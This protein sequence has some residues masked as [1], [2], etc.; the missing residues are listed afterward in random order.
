MP[1]SSRN[2]V[3]K[4]LGPDGVAPAP[5]PS[6]AAAALAVAAPSGF[7]MALA[8][9]TET[10]W[11]AWAAPTIVAAVWTSSPANARK[12]LRRPR[13]AD[14]G[15]VSADGSAA[16]APS[17]AWPAGSV[18]GVAAVGSVAGSLNRQARS[19]GSVLD[20]ARD[21]AA[22]EPVAALQ[23]LQLD[24]EGEADDLALESLH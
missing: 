13:S 3:R 4:P 6:L 21:A 9:S 17:A 22:V 12:N 19:D 23:E 16:G 20:D 24:E 8:A 5:G 15:P 11:R 10:C 1:P 2:G 7:R 14:A 18:G